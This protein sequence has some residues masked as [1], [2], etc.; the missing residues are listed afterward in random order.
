MTCSGVAMHGDE[1]DSYAGCDEGELGGEVGGFG[2]R[3]GGEPGQS[4]GPFDH[5]VA[6]PS[7]VGDD[8]VRACVVG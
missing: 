1:C 5:F 7:V 6:G 2:D 4:A 8:P 3:V